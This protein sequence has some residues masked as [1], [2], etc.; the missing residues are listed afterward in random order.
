[1]LTRYIR[2]YSN[3][4][5]VNGN[6]HYVEVQA[7]DKDG[8][9]VAY[10]KSLIEYSSDRGDK[11][12]YVTD[13][14]YSNTD[15]YFGMDTGLQYIVI[16]LE[17]VIDIVAIKLWRYYGDARIYYGTIIQTSIDN[18]NYTDVFNYET[19]GTYSET[20]AGKTI[21]LSAEPVNYT[22]IDD[23][24]SSVDNAIRLVNN[25]KYDDNTYA[26]D[27]VDWFDYAGTIASNIYASGN[28]WMGF[29]ASSEHLKVNRR[30]A[31][32]WNLWR[33]EA[34]YSTLLNKYNFLRI[35]WSGYETYNQTNSNYLI[36]YDVI[37]FET[38]DIM[39]YMV[40]IPTV[41]YNGAFTLGSLSY[42]KPTKDNRYVS[43]YKQADGSYIAK[44]EPINLASKR[45]LVRD[46]NTIYTVVDGVLAEITGELNSELFITSG[47]ADIPDG[48]LLMTL[49]APEVLCW[50]DATVAPTLTATVQGVPQSSHDITSDNI[51][52][53]HSSIYGITSIEAVASE[54]ATFLLSFDGGLWMSY[55]ASS[56]EWVNSDVGMTTAELIAIPENAWSSVINSATYMQLKAILDGVD[57]VT[58]IKFNFNNVSP[59]I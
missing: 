15:N 4:S 6:S 23:I 57:T 51:R 2:L 26:V 55:N 47:I 1:M 46:D 38:G 48:T 8:N 36:T 34:T 40:D 58:Q 30:D 27:G 37:L 29:G 33:E 12:E 44:Y 59:I 32:M 56:N 18:V 28:S 50:T 20:S 19:D 53:S 3:G 16:D 13:G 54:G 42:T 35:R 49:N 52:V 10:G 9:N 14:D 39:L 41:N 22:S 45:Y 43:F 5:N 7:L 24:V 21:Y 31:A 25:T 17:S 11:K